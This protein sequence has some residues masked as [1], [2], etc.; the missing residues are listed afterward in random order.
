[1][2]THTITDNPPRYTLVFCNRSSAMYGRTMSKR[3]FPPT[4]PT[5]YFSY[6]IL[7]ICLLTLRKSL[8]VI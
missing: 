4:I 6:T 7:P 8:A 1:M 3:Y 2:V 5:I